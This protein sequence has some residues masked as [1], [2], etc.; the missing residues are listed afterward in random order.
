MTSVLIDKAFPGLQKG[1]CHVIS[2]MLTRPT[3][4][5]VKKQD[6][7][8]VSNQTAGKEEEEEGMGWEGGHRG[9]RQNDSGSVGP[10]ITENQD[11]TR[12]WGKGEYQQC[13]CAQMESSGA[14][15]SCRV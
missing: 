11:W 7:C 5:G 14:L 2:R 1:Q 3:A 10:L 15:T 4:L 13:S 12:K 8:L 9:G 6:L